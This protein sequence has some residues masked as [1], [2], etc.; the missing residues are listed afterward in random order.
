MKILKIYQNGS[1]IDVKGSDSILIFES[2]DL[3][4]ITGMSNILYLDSAKGEFYYWDDNYILINSDVSESEV[5]FSYIDETGNNITSS[6]DLKT[7]LSNLATKQVESSGSINEQIISVNDEIAK[8]NNN[9]VDKVDGKGL[10]TEDFTSADKTKFD[11]IEDGAE[12]NKVNSVNGQTGDIEL[13]D[14][15]IKAS[16]NIN[17]TVHGKF[18]TIGAELKELKESI[19]TFDNSLGTKVDKEDGK[20]LS[21]NDY[22]NADK[23]KV[24]G[25]PENPKYT[26]TTYTEAT[27]SSSGLMSSV[28]KAKVDGIEAGAQKNKVS[29]VQ[30]KTGSVTITK[31]D[32]GLGNVENMGIVILSEAEYAALSD[33]EK[34]RKDKLYGTY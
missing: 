16:D 33:T 30:G 26:D 3:F 23:A 8:L 4:P 1:E 21:T 27:T 14:N 31:A 7:I 29:S 12:K 17:E 5:T 18:F 20:S 32:L 15:D 13:T 34:Q 10:S 9:K 11:G 25:I 22:T 6:S 28:D 24:D 19:N 2:K